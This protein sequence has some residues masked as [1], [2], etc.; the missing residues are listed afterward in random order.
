MLCGEWVLWLNVSK[1]LLDTFFNKVREASL[2]Q[3][4]SETFFCQYRWSLQEGI[5]YVLFP[6]LIWLQ[7]LFGREHIHGAH[8]GKHLGMVEKS[9]RE[10]LP[11][12]GA[13]DTN[14]QLGTGRLLVK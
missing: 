7:D 11:V 6:K 3:N 10:T 4:F 13:K 12:D 9:N 1:K 5:G 14:S 8:F 2:L